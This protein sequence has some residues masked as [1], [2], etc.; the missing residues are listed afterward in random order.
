MITVSAS[1]LMALSRISVTM[2]DIVIHLDSDA[3]CTVMKDVRRC[4]NVEKLRLRDVT[5]IRQCTL[6]LTSI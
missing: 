3:R 1:F 2:V 5:Y 6:T 4:F